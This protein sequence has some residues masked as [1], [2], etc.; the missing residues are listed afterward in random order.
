MS[1]GTPFVAKVGGQGKV[2]IPKNVRDLHA[3]RDGDY[4]SCVVI[5]K[6]APEPEPAS[7]PEG[8]PPPPAHQAPADAP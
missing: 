4:V 1:D 3:L 6:I 8:S 5:A 7:A 2:T